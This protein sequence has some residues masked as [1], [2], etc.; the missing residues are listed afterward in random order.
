MGGPQVGADLVGGLQIRLPPEAV[1]DPGGDDQGVVG[2]DDGRAVG[3]RPST[4]RAARSNP[5][6]VA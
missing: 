3:P 4:V 5:V 2:L 1:A 6:S